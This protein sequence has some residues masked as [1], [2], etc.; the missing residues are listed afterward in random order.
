MQ[1]DRTI[2]VRKS[3]V[4]A[5]WQPTERAPAK[6]AP[7]RRNGNSDPARLRIAGMVLWLADVRN[8]DY[9]SIA[10]LLGQKRQWVYAVTTGAAYR[11]AKPVEPAPDDYARPPRWWR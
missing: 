2:G 1:Y 10:T 3:L 4:N 6:R 11:H 7:D 5:L 9:G 8:L